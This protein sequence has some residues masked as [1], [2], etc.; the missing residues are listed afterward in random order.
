M[1]ILDIPIEWLI[2]ACFAVG[3]YATRTEIFLHQLKKDM[4]DIKDEIC[5][6][7]KKSKKV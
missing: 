1:V 2:V 6:E 4:K 3:G 7:D 5:P